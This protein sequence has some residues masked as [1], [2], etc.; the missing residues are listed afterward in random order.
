MR[1][2]ERRN[3]NRQDRHVSCVAC[4]SHMHPELVPW[5][6]HS[7]GCPVRTAALVGYRELTR[8]QAGRPLAT[9]AGS[10]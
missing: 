4:A 2:L 7:I 8:S 5:L 10:Q 1:T 3:R 9:S 6:Q